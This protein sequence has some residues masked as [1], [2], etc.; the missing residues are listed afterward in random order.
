M[1]S[2]LISQRYEILERVGEGPLFQVFKTRDRVLGRITAVKT[3]QAAHSLDEAVAAALRASANSV[4]QLS[5][6]HV[7][8]VFEI[9]DEN[10]VP[11]LVTEYVRGINLKDRIRRIAPFTLSV[12]VDFA[13]AI[14]EALQHAHAQGI[15]HG[16][17]RPQNVIISPEGALKVTDFG[18]APV[19]AASESV[20]FEH[21][22]R[23]APY[24]SPELA[25]GD[26][27]EAAGD[28]YGLGVVLFEMLTGSA[29]YL[30]DSIAGIQERHRSDTV[31]SPRSLNPGVPRSIEGIV[32]KC[33]QKRPEDRYPAAADLLNDLKSVRDALRFG[34]PLSWTPLGNLQAA[35]TPLATA[36]HALGEGALP[37]PALPHRE[38]PPPRGAPRMP[39]ATI[40]D[41]RISP[42]LKL[43]LATVTVLLIVVTIVGAAVWMATFSKP[44]DVKFPN[45]VGMTVEEAQ[46]A[47]DKA[48]VRLIE[49]QEYNEKHEPGV[50]YRV[51][52]QPGRA[53]RPG[54]SINIWI[55]RGSRMVWVPNLVK[56]YKDEAEKKLKEAGLILGEVDR[57]Y[58]SKVPLD[59]VAGQNPRSGKRVNRDVPINLVVS[60]G[61][62]PEP[63][64]DSTGAFGVPDPSSGVS[65][66]QGDAVE[67][68]E[69]Q[70]KNLEVTIKKDGRGMRRVR[71]EYDDARGTH[72]PV[73]EY[74]G[75]GDVVSHRVEVYGRKMTVRVYYDDDVTPIKE[76]ALELPRRRN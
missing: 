34:K 27:P 29:P 62:K 4:L 28:I 7:A 58:S 19:F 70:Y 51:D 64:P 49:H 8:R 46:V 60:D 42:F 73:D 13:I 6:T 20:R 15:V 40:N 9:A 74:H 11:A 59:H 57:Q 69:P 35:A 12:A 23:A 71:V 22:E 63:E 75:E 2:R 65:E 36:V 16:D 37:A 44:P 38:N 67:N 72:T 18:M 66:P 43:A 76:E 26:A 31:P 25:E 48:N 39:V 32:M 45:L 5:H 24:Q 41:D 33:L 21:L 50:I 3:I 30:G 56:L 1:V 68:A 14:G 17:V 10:G 54:R 61:P 53:V 52:W 55:S 47:A